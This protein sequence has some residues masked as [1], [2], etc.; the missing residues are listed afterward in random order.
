MERI[1]QLLFGPFR[2]DPQKKQ[3]WK[4]ETVL[5]LR[6]MCG[7]VVQVLLEHAGEV[8]TKEQLLRSVWT[9]TYVSGTALKVCIREIRETLGDDRMAPRYIE[10]VGR[11][12]YR[13][14]GTR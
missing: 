7:S 4:G 9:G 1:A 2:L 14:I 10:T 13:F 12:G 5:E 3:L 8:L 11:E 6:P